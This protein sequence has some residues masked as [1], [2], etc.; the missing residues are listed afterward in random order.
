MILSR[1]PFRLQLGG[2]STDLPSYYQE[3]GGFIFSVAIN[4]YMYVTLNRPPVDDLIRLKYRESEEVAHVSEIKHR[5]ART[6]LEHLGIGKMVELSSLAD[7]PD[8]TGLGS[9]G[10]YVVGLLNVL[11]NLR[12]EQ[13]TAVELAEEAFTIVNHDLKLPDGKQDFYATALGGFAALEIEQNGSVTVTRPEISIATRES[14]EKRLLLFYS[15]IRRSSEGILNEQQDS[16]QGGNET[17]IQLK[18]ETKR[19]GREILSAFERDDLDKYGHLL[20]EHWELKKQM[21]NNMSNPLFD[22]LYTH[23]LRKGA[24]GGKIVGAGGGGFFMAFCEDGAQ[25]AVRSIY[26][27]ANFREVPFKIDSTG[28]KVLLNHPRSINRD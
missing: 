15:G 14:F 3:Y 9:S 13:L 7:V 27:D 21:T 24:M 2:G 1:T 26:E 20:H 6:A 19:V 17:V 4:L 10:S 22:S 12:G 28:T 25:A 18:H 23:A 8:G 16:V 11:H 5:F